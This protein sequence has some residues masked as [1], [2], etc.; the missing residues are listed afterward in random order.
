MKVKELLKKVNGA[1][2]R[3]PVF[4]EDIGDGDSCREVHGPEFAGH[5]YEEQDRTV[6]NI[7]IRSD[8]VVVY[9]K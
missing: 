3:L 9:Y 2:A 1:S 4:I 6:A 8:R 5:Y 7:A